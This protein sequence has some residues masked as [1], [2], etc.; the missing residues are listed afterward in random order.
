MEASEPQNDTHTRGTEN[1]CKDPPAHKNQGRQSLTTDCVCVL[2]ASPRTR[3]RP[4]A[5]CPSPSLP[6]GPTPH[7][8]TSSRVRQLFPRSLR[9]SSVK[10]RHSAMAEEESSAVERGDSIPCAAHGTGDGRNGT[11]G[12]C[13]VSL[14]PH[15]STNATS[16]RF[17]R[18]ALEGPTGL[19][20]RGGPGPG[21]VGRAPRNLFRGGVSPHPT[22][23]VERVST[24]TANAAT[25]DAAFGRVFLRAS[26]GDADLRSVHRERGREHGVPL[27]SSLL[28]L[29]HY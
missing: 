2:R 11:L 23:A 10:R 14:P 20:K 24:A 27:F 8:Q 26:R 9:E 3:V 4:V 13:P 28:S 18:L 29:P 12:A 22:I 25:P 6:E 21:T 5:L 1:S 7:G 17:A 15:P 19:S 16:V